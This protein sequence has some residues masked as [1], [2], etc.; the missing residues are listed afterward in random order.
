MGVSRAV[1][2]MDMQKCLA[3][4]QMKQQLEADLTELTLAFQL[5]LECTENLSLSKIASAKLENTAHGLATHHQNEA[6][7]PDQT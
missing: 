3:E 6:L 1:T 5:L 7:I 2:D 4:I